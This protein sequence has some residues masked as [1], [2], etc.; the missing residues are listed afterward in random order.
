MIAM[1]IPMKTQYKDG[2][3][4]EYKAVLYSVRKNHSL[5]TENY[6]TGCLIG[7]E[8]RILNLTVY[9]DSEFV[10]DNI[11]HVLSPAE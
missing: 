5:K 9:D 6:R 11:E 1:L 8:V 3:T 2:G 7:T 10:P 4:V